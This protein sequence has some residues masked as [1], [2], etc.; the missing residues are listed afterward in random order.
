MSTYLA[1]ELSQ[2]NIMVDENISLILAKKLN[3]LSKFPSNK[4][5][6]KSLIQI[7]AS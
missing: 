1:I 5:L 7:N 2:K 6:I 4:Q 3:L